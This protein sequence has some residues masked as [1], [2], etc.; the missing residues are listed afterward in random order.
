MTNNG[1]SRKEFYSVLAAMAVGVAISYLMAGPQIAIASAAA[2]LISELAD[3]AV[4]SFTKRPLSQRIL[5]SSVLGTPIDTVVFLTM[6]GFFSVTGA[7]VMTASKLLGALIV[8]L[9]IRRR[10]LTGAILA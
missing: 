10:E 2:F 3:W 6:I 1:L 9:L 4:Y 8:W 5:F 7:V